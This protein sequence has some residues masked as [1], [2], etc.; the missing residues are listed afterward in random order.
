V[1]RGE[2]RAGDEGVGVGRLVRLQ[3]LLPVAD[4]DL[5]AAPDLLRVRQELAQAETL[6][7]GDVLRRRRVRRLRGPRRPDRPRQGD[8]GDD[9]GQQEEEC[10]FDPP[11]GAKRGRGSAKGALFNAG[12]VGCGVCFEI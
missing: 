9:G 1:R 7:T 4:A 8:P 5:D 6:R 2:T 12:A 3:P 11:R 10:E